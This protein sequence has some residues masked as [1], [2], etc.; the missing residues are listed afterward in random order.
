MV[1]VNVHPTK[2]IVHFLNEERIIK[3]IEQV[4]ENYL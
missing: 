3:V 4:V 2:A 1:D